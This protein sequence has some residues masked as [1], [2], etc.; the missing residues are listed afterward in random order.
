MSQAP[1][2]D[3][4]SLAAPEQLARTMLKQRYGRLDRFVAG[5]PVVLVE[6]GHNPLQQRLD[7]E[8]VDIDDVLEAA[9]RWRGLERVDQIRFAVLE[10]DGNI[11]IASRVDPAAGV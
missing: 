4:H 11:T 7:L 2:E 3:L 5:E 8:R 1:S 9:R 10:R 6:N